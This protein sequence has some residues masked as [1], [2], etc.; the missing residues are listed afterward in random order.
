MTKLSPEQARQMIQRIASQS[1]VKVER[2]SSGGAVSG[3]PG[4]GVRQQSQS[5]AAKSPDTSQPASTVNTPSGGRPAQEGVRA[6]RSQ[7][8]G[9]QPGFGVRRANPQP[10]NTTTDVGSSGPSVVPASGQSSQ[11]SQQRSW[12]EQGADILKD[13]GAAVVEG[14]VEALAGTDSTVPDSVEAEL[15]DV[16]DGGVA[17]QGDDSFITESSEPITVVPGFKFA[18]IVSRRKGV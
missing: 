17:Q 13:V 18:R 12:L 10:R 5:V 4:F 8:Q 1:K 3:T 6:V 11:Q 2:P 7:A 16:S 9:V 14:A 15:N